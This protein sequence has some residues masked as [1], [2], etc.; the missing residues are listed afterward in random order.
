MKILCV[1]VS[2]VL[3]LQ[4]FGCGYILHPERRNQVPSGRIDPGIAILDGLWLLVF[5]IPGVIAFAVDVTNNT[6]YLPGGQRRH[7]ETLDGETLKKIVKEETGISI[8][9]NEA[10][11]YGV[12]RSENIEA[13]LA[14]IENSGYRYGLQ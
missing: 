4:L 14:E 10:Q 2:I 12:D 3:M 5:I 11:V 6:L 7:S 1:I 8:N 13:K 9:L